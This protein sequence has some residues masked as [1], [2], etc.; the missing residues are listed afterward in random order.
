MLF[1]LLQYSSLHLFCMI[2]LMNDNS[3]TLFISPNNVSEFKVGVKCS[4]LLLFIFNPHSYMCSLIRG[5]FLLHLL[6]WWLHH[7]RI[8]TDVFT[9]IKFQALFWRFP[10]NSLMQILTCILNKFCENLKLSKMLLSLTKNIIFRCM[11]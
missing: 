9:F 11:I 10:W 5:A 6:L 8:I 2:I 4:V 3:A 1:C 7:P